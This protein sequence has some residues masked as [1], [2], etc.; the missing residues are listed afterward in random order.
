MRKEKY[1]GQNRDKRM[2]AATYVG[3]ALLAGGAGVNKYMESNEK[4][5]HKACV[6]IP[7]QDG[8][9]PELMLKRFDKAN[10]NQSG[11]TIVFK[12]DGEVLISEDGFPSKNGSTEFTRN[13]FVSLELAD[14]EGCVNPL[15]GGTVSESLIDKD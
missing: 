5:N 6:N 15:V 4:E 1:S 8:D 10:L 3:I 9:G 2:A 7:V 13:D 11:Q 12:A 14:P